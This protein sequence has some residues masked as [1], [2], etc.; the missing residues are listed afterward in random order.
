MDFR[1]EAWSLLLILE[2]GRA[3]PFLRSQEFQRILV[4]QRSYAR[5]LMLGSSA[6]TLVTGGRKGNS[7]IRSQEFQRILFSQR[8]YARGS[9]LG[10]AALTLVTGGRKGNSVLTR[11]TTG[12]HSLA[13]DMGLHAQHRNDTEVR[14]QP[15]F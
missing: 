7:R 4:S 5:G 15:S 1:L 3:T 10:S 11:S 8:S 12:S 2:A 14:T 6:L 13:C 9:L